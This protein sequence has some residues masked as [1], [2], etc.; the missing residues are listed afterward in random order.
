MRN[1]FYFIIVAAIYQPAIAQLLYSSHSSHISF[2][3]LPES[4]VALLQYTAVSH[5]LSKTYLICE[6]PDKLFVLM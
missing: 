1:K 6:I 2:S 5:S 3:T 4:E